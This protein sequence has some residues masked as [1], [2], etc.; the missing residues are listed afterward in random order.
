MATEKRY[1]KNSTCHPHSIYLLLNYLGMPACHPLPLTLTKFTTY[2]PQLI[3]PHHK[4]LTHIHLYNLPPFQS[5]AYLRFSV[6]WWRM[7][8]VLPESLPMLLFLWKSLKIRIRSTKSYEN[9]P[10]FWIKS[11]FILNYSKL[12]HHGSPKVISISLFSSRL[13]LNKF[14]KAVFYNDTLYYFY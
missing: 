8:P 13:K 14:F 11:P 12:A 1:I 9:S 7:N 2:Y 5:S 6:A 10:M 4:V 3:Q